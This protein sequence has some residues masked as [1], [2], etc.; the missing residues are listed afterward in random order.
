MHYRISTYYGLYVRLLLEHLAS[1]PRNQSPNRRRHRGRARSA[2]LLGA[3][4]LAEP[5]H[6]ALGQLLAA[7]EALDPAVER[8][9]CGG[10]CGED[11]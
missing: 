5:L 8:G 1:L 10:L 11:R 3:Y 6:V 4:L 7:H 2:P 9:N